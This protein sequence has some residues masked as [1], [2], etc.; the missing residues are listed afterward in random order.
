MKFTSALIGASLLLG[1]QAF[2]G[3]PMPID[4]ALKIASDYLREQ[5]FAKDHAIS[6]LA[7]EP[8][9]LLRKDF[10]WIAQ[11]SPTIDRGERQETGLQIS[12]DGNVARIVTK[13]AQ[14]RAHEATKRGAQSMR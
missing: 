13:S 2:A 9:T 11:W 5:G 8:T 4:Q 12:A 7:L 1:S 3:A 6:S 14:E 10:R